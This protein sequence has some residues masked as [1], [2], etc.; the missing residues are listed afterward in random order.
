M[1]LAQVRSQVRS[2]VRSQLARGFGASGSSLPVQGDLIAMSVVNGVVASES[3]SPTLQG[4]GIALRFK[5]MGRRI[6]FTAGGETADPIFDASTLE[7]TVTDP[8]FSGPNAPVTRTRT[9]RGARP[10]H[11]PWPRTWAD[12]PSIVPPRTFVADNITNGGNAY[13][14][15]AGGTKGGSAPTAFSSAPA[16]NVTDGSVTWVPVPLTSFNGFVE[17]PSGDDVDVIVIP[18]DAFYVGTQILGVSIGA[19]A[20]QAQGVSSRASSLMP[21]ATTQSSTLNYLPPAITAMTLPHQLYQGAACASIRTEWQI[22]DHAGRFG[23]GQAIAGIRTRAVDASF[24][25]LNDWAEC[26]TSELSTQYTTA[27]SP[28]GRALEVYPT[29]NNCSAVAAGLAG[30]ELEVFP[31]IGPVWRSREWGEGAPWTAGQAVHLHA[32]RR[33]GGNLY[34][35]TTAGTTGTTAPSHTTST[36]AD[37]TAQALFLGAVP[38]AMIQTANVPAAWQFRNDPA[39]VWI[40]GH[41]YVNASGNPSGTPTAHNSYAAARDAYLAGNSF[42]TIGAAL[43]A[44]R[45]FHNTAQA[46]MTIHDDLAGGNVWLEGGVHNGVGATTVSTPTGRI[47]CNVRNDPAHASASELRTHSAGTAKPIAGMMRWIGPRLTIGGQVTGSPSIAT[48]TVMT[49]TLDSGAA[50]AVLSSAMAFDG[51]I[52]NQLVGPSGGEIVTGFGSLFFPNVTFTGQVLTGNAST[53]MSTALVAGCFADMSASSSGAP[54]NLG[55]RNV[56]ACRMRGSTAS[57]GN[58]YFNTGR[59]LS[60]WSYLPMHCKIVNCSWT[61]QPGNSGQTTINLQGLQASTDVPTIAMALAGNIGE[62][63][64]RIASLFADS[65]GTV[66]SG[67]IIH[68]NTLPGA[69]VND[70]Y[71]E[72][73]TTLHQH[74]YFWHNW[75]TENNTVWDHSSHSPDSQRRTAPRCQNYWPVFKVGSRENINGFGATNGNDPGNPIGYAPLRWPGWWKQFTTANIA[76]EFGAWNVNGYGGTGTFNGDYRPNAGTFTATARTFRTRR[77]ALDGTALGTTGAIGALEAA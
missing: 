2:P 75:F 27:A 23:L 63:N 18:D 32:V 67:L 8:G 28:S 14:T 38:T 62:G 24:T 69:R 39:S 71:N 13:Y 56:L 64:N 20:Y 65:N 36:V 44:L 17:I 10:L 4:I 70:G 1:A 22:E 53:R 42:G 31:W 77:F 25:P 34:L 68:S 48:N 15:V 41:V 29:I 66:S 7:I 9:I 16:G 40:T 55:R 26:A 12:V 54:C 33:A 57:T 35:Y 21:A 45:T 30:F 50:Y 76:A 49:S 3:A 58:A 52:N 19:G 73:N 72:I 43:L 11:R 47:W 5:G 60:G 6:P 37:G 74:F 59:G 51:T 46:G 61:T